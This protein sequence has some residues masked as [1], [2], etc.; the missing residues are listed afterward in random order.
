MNDLER[1]F[2][3]NDGKLINKWMHYFDV[4]DRHFSKFRGKEIVVLEIGVYQGGS[5]Q[6]WKNYF[7]DKAKIYGIDVNPHCKELEEDN[8]EIIIGSQS[9]RNFLG[10]IK[11][12][13][14]G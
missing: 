6:M 2:R 10:K 14:R 7:G 9:D 5:L 13:Y 12:R 11:N 3:N 4:Y 1:Y 8:V